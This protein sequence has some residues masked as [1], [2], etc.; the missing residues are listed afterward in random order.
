MKKFLLS[1]FTL[2]SFISQAQKYLPIDSTNIWLTQRQFRYSSSSCC[3]GY[4]Y[5]SF[6]FHDFV[7]NNGRKWLKLHQSAVYTN[8]CQ[9]CPSP[10]NYYNFTDVPIGYVFDDSLNKKVYFI[11]TLPA[12]FTP[13]NSELF[14][15]YLNKNIGDSLVWK[16]LLTTVPATKF[17]INSI[18]SILLA[19]KY[20]KRFNAT[21]TTNFSQP[22]TIAV[23]EGIGSTLG[24]WNSVFTD[25]EANSELTCFSK[26]T[27]G[28]GVSNYTNFNATSSQCNTIT[29]VPET[30]LLV[31]SIHPNPT[32]SQ[33][34]I[35]NIQYDNLV[36]TDIFG[37]TVLEQNYYASKISV[38]HLPKGLY[39]LQLRSGNNVYASKFI[40]E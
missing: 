19:G 22:R 28:Y 40:K 10:F 17:K 7:T 24:P 25:F 2:I 39:F 36:V 15:D 12:N 18:D 38:Q 9:Q 6:Q 30:E 3:Y 20:H 26:P 34:L 27:Q 21:N 11:S 13:G 33:L 5:A 31:F 8:M 4:E 14:Y 35:E 29:T 37:K 1:L 32:A 16:S 23:I